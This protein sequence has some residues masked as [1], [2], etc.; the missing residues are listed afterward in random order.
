MSIVL[1]DLQTKK[2][3]FF[4][5]KGADSSM[6]EQAIRRPSESDG[7]FIKTID[8]Y[9]VTGL[10]TLVYVRTSGARSVV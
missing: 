2:I 4:S 6:L 8:A 3:V 7:D 10:R 5:G 1:R 9:A